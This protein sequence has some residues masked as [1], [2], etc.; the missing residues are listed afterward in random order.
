MC[1]FFNTNKYENYQSN[2]KEVLSPRPHTKKK[3]LFSLMPA[4]LSKNNQGF[5]IIYNINGRQVIRWDVEAKNRE[6]Q[7][8]L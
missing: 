1:I 4:L 2:I 8:E 6:E 7:E 5:K 3:N